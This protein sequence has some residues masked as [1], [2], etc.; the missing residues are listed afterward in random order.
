MI[1]REFRRKIFSYIKNYIR[2]FT[3]TLLQDLYIAKKKKKKTFS[4]IESD[5]VLYGFVNNYKLCL[6]YLTY[7]V[8][9]LKS[10]DNFNLLSHISVILLR[11][12]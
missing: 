5:M 11:C 10:R 6:C 9:I 12:Q 7:N 8:I 2:H 3:A 4:N 1:A